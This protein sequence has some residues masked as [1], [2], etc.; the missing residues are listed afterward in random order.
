MISMS[1]LRQ[2]WSRS[3]WNAR[4]VCINHWYHAVKTTLDPNR[5]KD[6]VSHDNTEEEFQNTPS[7]GKF[8]HP[9][10]SHGWTTDPKHQS[11]PAEAHMGPESAHF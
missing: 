11:D 9:W 6:S 8:T 2:Q 1:S 7:G 5:K 10:D 4:G 3:Y